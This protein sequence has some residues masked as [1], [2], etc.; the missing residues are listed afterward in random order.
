MTW[1][2]AFSL[3]T[4][5]GRIWIDYEAHYSQLK[6]MDGWARFNG[7]LD[8]KWV[9]SKTFFPATLL[10]RYWKLLNPTKLT[11]QNRSGNTETQKIK[12]SKYE[13]NI[14][15]SPGGNPLWLQVDQCSMEY[16]ETKPAFWLGMGFCSVD[17]SCQKQK[18]VFGH[19]IQHKSTA[20]PLTLCNAD[21]I[22]CQPPN[23]MSIHAFCCSHCKLVKWFTDE[24]NSQQ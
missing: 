14:R 1:L 16:T 12:T 7:P 17:L 5:F 23:K 2:F 19:I 18:P 8:T 11:I 9:I 4:L 22:N 6:Q 10:A 13:T 3:G 15:Y 24:H 20:M 21:K